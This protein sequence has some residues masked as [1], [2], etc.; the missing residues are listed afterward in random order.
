MTDSVTVGWPIQVARVLS[1]L[2]V[3]TAATNTEVLTML[4]DFFSENTRFSCPRCFFVIYSILFF[5]APFV[6]LVG[7]LCARQWG[8]IG[9]FIFPLIALI[10]EVPAIPFIGYFLSNDTIEWFNLSTLINIFIIVI[11]WIL[12]NKH[13]K[14]TGT[15]IA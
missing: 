11:V 4:F 3:I 9:L 1:V 13:R 15:N 14:M 6:A 10:F 7:L 8:F 12:F 5:T 2:T